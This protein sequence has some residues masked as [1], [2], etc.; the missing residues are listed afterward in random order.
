MGLGSTCTLN[1]CN[2]ARC[3]LREA[4]YELQQRSFP[5]PAAP[6]D[7]PHLLCRHSQAHICQQ[8]RLATCSTQTHTT[9]HHQVA[10]LVLSAALFFTARQCMRTYHNMLTARS[11]WSNVS[12]LYCQMCTC[13]VVAQVLDLNLSGRW[14][15]VC[16]L[17][18]HLCLYSLHQICKW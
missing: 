17:S 15:I 10:L 4:G 14:S 9:L 1:N 18:L 11:F 3:G 12:I 16:C 2:A 7:Q 8:G 13:G 5:G 6:I